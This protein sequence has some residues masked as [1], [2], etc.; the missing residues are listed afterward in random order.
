MYD[1]ETLVLEDV[2]QMLQNNEL[3][4]KIESAEEALGLVVK[5]QRR[6][7]KS[8]EPKRNS[9]ASSSFSCYFCNKPGH[10]KKNCMKY[11]EML[12]RKGDRF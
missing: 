2:R 9:G 11:K 8:R 5:G 7:S 6:R 1:K 12:K 4:K 3:M 10:I